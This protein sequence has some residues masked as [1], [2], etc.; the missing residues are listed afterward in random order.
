MPADSTYALFT[1]IHIDNNNNKWLTTN[2]GLFKFD[3]STWTHYNSSNTAIAF[4]NTYSIRSDASGII[5]AITQPN[6][7]N[8]P[9]LAIFKNGVW[10]SYP[11]PFNAYKIYI[12]KASTN[13]FLLDGGTL[14][15][16]NGSGDYS[17][18]SSYT[19]VVGIPGNSSDCY[20]Y[21]GIWYCSFT[22]SNAYDN[23]K[24]SGFVSTDKN[25]SQPVYFSP[26][27]TYIKMNYII[28][29]DGSSIILVGTS[30]NS[31]SVLNKLYRY[32]NGVWSV[33]PYNTADQKLEEVSSIAIAK[34]GSLWIG[35]YMDGFAKYYNDKFTF[36]TYADKIPVVT[37]I[38][39]DD[40]NIKW[41]ATQYG[42]LL[43][44]TAQ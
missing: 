10:S 15:A 37:G 34:D 30:G 43:K 29:R 32:Q 11:L 6:V 27:P 40:K 35:S 33:I 22:N 7:N 14:Y 36:Y 2:E 4:G 25:L 1:S 38:A 28:T 41:I 9:L 23:N 16:Y 31:G 13:L 21:N 12:N 19:K 20:F 5:Y 42:G 17:N 26:N 3:G 24:Y 44:C 39:V 8:S 18:Y